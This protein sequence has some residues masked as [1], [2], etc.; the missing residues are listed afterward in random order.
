MGCN[1]NHA[2]RNI[3]VGYLPGD[4]EQF[5]CAAGI[6]L[7]FGFVFRGEFRKVRV[8]PGLPTLTYERPIETVRP[9]DAPVKGLPLF[10]AAWVPMGGGGVAIEIGVAT[11]IVILFGP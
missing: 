2:A 4:R 7:V 5:V 8:S 10:T 6:K 3:V 1:R 9:I 11:D